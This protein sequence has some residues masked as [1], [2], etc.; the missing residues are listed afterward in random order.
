MCI[1]VVFGHTDEE[2]T[3]AKWAVVNAFRRALDGGLSHFDA[4]RALREVLTRAHGSN[5]EQWAAE[6]AEALV[7]TIAQLQAAVA[8]DDARQVERLRLEC[9]SLR[10]VVADYNAHP[11]QAQVQAL[12]AERDR[13]RAEADR[14]ANRVRTLEDAL[15]RAQQAHQTEV[16]RLQATIA[17]L[18][19]IVAEQ[20]RQLNDLMEG[21][22]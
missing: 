13:R 3:E 9:D 22:I 2:L 5:P 19:R 12:T 1:R 21:A 8:S 4:R 17:D 10:R 20:Q 6:V 7:E 18:N 14:L 15:R 16:A 11:L